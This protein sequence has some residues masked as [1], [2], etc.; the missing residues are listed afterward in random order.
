MSES[1][2][3][4]R[5]PRGAWHIQQCLPITSAPAGQTLTR[6]QRLW[7]GLQQSFR[8]MVGVHDYQTYLKHMREHHPEIA[9][10][11]ERAFHRHCLDARFPSQPGKL[12]KCPC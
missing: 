9:P 11:N 4:W 12:G 6:W 5:K 8:L 7:Q 10:M 2:F 1:I 3:H